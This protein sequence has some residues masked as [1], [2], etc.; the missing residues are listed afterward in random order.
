MN[1]SKPAV[2]LA[3]LAAG[4][5]INF[6]MYRLT[7]WLGSQIL[8]AEEDLVRLERMAEE[9]GQAAA[10]FRSLR[11]MKERDMAVFKSGLSSLAQTKK[12]LYESGLSL[13]EEKRLLEKL[14]EIMTTSIRVPCGRVWSCALFRGSIAP[15]RSMAPPAMRK[16]PRR[17]WSQACTRR[18][19]CWS[20]R[21]RRWTGQT[22]I[23]R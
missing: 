23:W 2:G 15:G 18:R 22:P 4:L 8:A 21:P 14:L 19:R 10:E 13:Q 1:V 16:L 12:T 6:G 5:L 11:E 3:V 7:Q 17:G 9:G 20:V